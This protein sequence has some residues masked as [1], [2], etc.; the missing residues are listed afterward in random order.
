MNCKIYF[1]TT[2]NGKNCDHCNASIIAP[3]PIQEDEEAEQKM[4]KNH[5]S[6]IMQFSF[7]IDSVESACLFFTSGDAEV[8]IWE[9][10]WAEHKKSTSK[11]QYDLMLSPHHCSWHALSYD[12]WSKIRILKLIKMPNALLRKCVRVHSSYRAVSQ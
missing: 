8:Y 5:S 10:L 3:F 1:V 4:T 11:L 2:P 9:K 7:K 6:V 12:S